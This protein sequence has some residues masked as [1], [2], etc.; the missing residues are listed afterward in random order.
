MRKRGALYALWQHPDPM[1][2]LFGQ[3]VSQLG[4]GVGLVALTL[5]VL[6]TT[7]SPSKLAWTAAAR[8]TPQVAFLLIGGVIVD[9]FSRRILLLLSDV[10]R[11]LLTG[12]LVLVLVTHSLHFWELIVYAVAFG[13]FDALFFPAMS[14]LIPE[15][16]PE[17]LLPAMNSLRPLTN[18]LMGQMIGPAIGGLLVAISTTWAIGLDC[19]TFF[20]SAGALTLM[21]A[22]PR[23]TSTHAP[24]MWREIREGL[25]YVRTTSWLWTT[26]VAVT[27]TNAFVFSPMSVLIP[28]YLRHHL[29]EG[30]A[31]VGYAFAV[32]G[33]TGSVGALISAHLPSPRRRVRVM[34]MYWSI[35]T[36]AGLI[37]AIATNLWLVLLF[38]LIASPFMLFGNVIWESMMQ[39]EVPR[40]LL[41]RTSSIDWFVSLGMMP[42]GLVVAGA[43]ANIFSVGTYYLIAS[44]VSAV[45]GIAI[46]L[47]HRANAI[48]AARL[49]QSPTA[50]HHETTA[51]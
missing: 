23:P 45:P 10:A 29:H 1:R 46:L 34:W 7:H 19:L 3:A 48:D 41:G 51:P 24:N 6:D 11:G 50:A 14:A 44:L 42:I 49:S 20:V 12:G 25:R 8:V 21:R 13:V 37:M 36:L 15:I 17:D 27:L 33:L 39:S 18:N 35:A 47:S 26:L 38:P 32:S 5:L 40:E 28:Y 30:K 43:L 9:R 31:V 22:T 4:D 2:L 16:V